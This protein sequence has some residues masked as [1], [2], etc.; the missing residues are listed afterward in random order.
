ME[1]ERE[2]E[3]GR[4]AKY[5]LYKIFLKIANGSKKFDLFVVGLNFRN[6]L[7]IFWS[8]K[9]LPPKNFS[10]TQFSKTLILTKI[11]HPDKLFF[12]ST[13]EIN[14]FEP[15]IINGTINLSCHGASKFKLYGS[16]DFS[17][18]RKLGRLLLKANTFPIF[19]S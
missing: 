18:N 2:G 1:R 8:F 4:R 9:N 17:L 14:Q 16:E 11:W 12:G 5:H 10:S 3:W 19:H 13:L 15:Q 6:K 7:I